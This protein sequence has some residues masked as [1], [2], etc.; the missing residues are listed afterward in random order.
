MKGLFFL[1]VSAALV[2]VSVLYDGYLKMKV[3]KNYPP[4]NS[5]DYIYMIVA[6]STD[7]LDN[8]FEALEDPDSSVRPAND[9][10]IFTDTNWHPPNPNIQT[11]RKDFSSPDSA[12]NSLNTFVKDQSS[13]KIVNLVGNVN[14]YTA[15]VIVNTNN[16]W[17]VPSAGGSGWTKR[18]NG[19]YKKV[20]NTNLGVTLIEI[21]YSKYVSVLL[22]IPFQGREEEVGKSLTSATIEALRKSMTLQQVSLEVPR[23]TLYTGSFTSVDIVP[24]D[25]EELIRTKYGY[26]V[27]A[28][29]P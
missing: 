24:L 11:V 7:A 19:E 15:A 22:A 3:N 2:H 9:V 12:M 25:D 28:Q 16:A 18:L 29:F 5:Q 20:E 4:L 10:T 26:K 1:C 27:A 23:A 13:G 21:P 17:K 8:L 14:E 6:F